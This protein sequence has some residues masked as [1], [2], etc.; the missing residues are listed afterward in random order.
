MHLSRERVLPELSASR[1]EKRSM[2]VRVIANPFYHSL[3]QIWIPNCNMISHIGF[4]FQYSAP[5]IRN[6]E[7]SL[8][9]VSVSLLEE[10]RGREFATGSFKL[11]CEGL[12]VSRQVCL[13]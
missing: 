2:V 6:M 9:E 3:L 5:I 13:K 7:I 12:E 4:A 11:G 10:L 1:R 8:R